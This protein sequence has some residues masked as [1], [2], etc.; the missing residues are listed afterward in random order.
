MIVHVTRADVNEGICGD[1][2]NCPVALAIANTLKVDHHKVV[3]T[4]LLITVNAEPYRT[5]VRVRAFIR[6]FDGGDPVKP[7]AFRLQRQTEVKAA[8]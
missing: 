2:S 6:K 1:P 4:P 8:A 5:P 7:F 3:V